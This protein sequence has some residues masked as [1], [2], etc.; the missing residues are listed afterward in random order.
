[1]LGIP[2]QIVGGVRFYQRKEIKDILSYLRM[3]INPDDDIA[4][5]HVVNMSPVVASAIQP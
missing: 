5:T 1:M 2:Y 4:F 3:L